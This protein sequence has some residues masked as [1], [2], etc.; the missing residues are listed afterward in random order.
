MTLKH[1]SGQQEG[2]FSETGHSQGRLECGVGVR[3]GLGD[4]LDFTQ[5]PEV[6]VGQPC[7]TLWLPGAT[8]EELSGAPRDVH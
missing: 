4:G 7:P 1:L 5:A 2:P 8:W 3:K 6:L